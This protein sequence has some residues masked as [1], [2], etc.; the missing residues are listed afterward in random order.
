M[1]RGAFGKWA[2]VALALTVVVACAPEE[3]KL[4]NLKADNTGPDEFMI[5]PSKPLESPEDFEALPEPTP[6]GTNRT[7]PTP[8]ADAVAAL[9]GKPERLE[10]NGLRSGEAALVNHAS[11]YGRNGEIRDVLAAEDL[12]FRRRNNGRLLER[13]FNVSVYFKAYAAQSLD[14]YYELERLRRAGIW[15]PAVPPEGAQQ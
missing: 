4:L 5:L 1:M 14:Q 6:G 15:T 9:G 10:R 13:L 3:P 7:D 11:R 8:E 12:E 2:V